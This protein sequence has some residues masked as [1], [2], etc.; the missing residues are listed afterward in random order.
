MFILALASIAFL[1]IVLFMIVSA[2]DSEQKI[3][4]GKAIT[5]CGLCNELPCQC[6]QVLPG[7][8][9]CPVC[10]LNSIQQTGAAG[11]QNCSGCRRAFRCPGCLLAK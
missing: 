2:N 6:A 9:R 5:R 3:G 8:T 7:Q 1:A 4:N 11:I 10:G